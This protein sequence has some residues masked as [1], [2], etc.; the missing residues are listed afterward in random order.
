MGNFVDLY[1]DFVERTLALVEQYDEIMEIYPF[2]EQYNHTLLINCLLGLA[3]LPNEKI[4]NFAPKEKIQVVKAR[5]GFVNSTFDASIKDTIDLIVEI[6]HCA[7]HFNIEFV[8]TDDNNHIN[9]IVFRNDRSGIAVADFDA[10]ELRPFVRWFG[11][12]LL[13]NYKKRKG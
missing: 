5:E 13:E 9:R 3:V 7:A 4:I 8:S 1:H 2:H 11:T 10:M 6:R 12:Q